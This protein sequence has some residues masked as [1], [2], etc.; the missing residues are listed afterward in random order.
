[1]RPEIERFL[2]QTLHLA[3]DSKL[4]ADHDYKVAIKANI[5]QGV[6]TMDSVIGAM[7]VL[8]RVAYEMDCEI[9]DLHAQKVE[10]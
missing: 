10:G 3:S 7:T 4:Q 8:E 5:A 6:L 1:M 2:R 9:G